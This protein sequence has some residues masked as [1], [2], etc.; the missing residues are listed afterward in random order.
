MKTARAKT[1]ALAGVLSILVGSSGCADG[2]LDVRPV[3]TSHGDNSESDLKIADSALSGENTD[4][5]GTLYERVLTAHPDSIRAR[6]G[7]ADVAYQSGDLNRAQVLY[8]QAASQAPNQPGAQLGLAR[9]ALRQ[10][11]LDDAA[12]LYRA[13]LAAQPDN[14]LAAEG[15]GT[16]LDLQ[17]H[18]EQAQAVYR[19]ALQAHPDA[20]GIR[21][22]LGLSL[23][24]SNRAREGV[25]TL[26]DVAG[27]SDA[28]WQARQNLAFGYGV[29]GKPDSARKVLQFDLPPSAVDDNL[30][31]YQTV[32][33]KLAVRTPSAV[34]P[35]R[36]ANEEGPTSTRKQ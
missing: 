23:V 19:R 6:L 36:A 22:D 9:V 31:V 26:L 13:L 25:N 2:R 17:Q 18:H 3:Q 20:Q 10:R 7:L 27:L 16:V 4:L 35:P 15:L 24:L 32:R 12:M 21:I 33:A 1:I 14:V 5:A 8:S 30:R 29:L 34:P 11:R 28:P